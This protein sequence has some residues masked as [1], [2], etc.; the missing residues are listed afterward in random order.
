MKQTRI[1]LLT[2]KP[3]IPAGASRKTKDAIHRLDWKYF[4][5]MG[6]ACEIEQ[7]DEIDK[8]YDEALKELLT[9]A[10]D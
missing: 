4:E 9:A 5:L 8:A 3:L 2:G 6:G 7:M 10:G 1:N